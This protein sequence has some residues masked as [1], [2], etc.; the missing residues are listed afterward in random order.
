M[1]ID[2][3]NAAYG[4]VCRAI[5]DMSSAYHLMET[6]PSESRA[7]L[8]SA[9]RALLELK[10][11][12][13]KPDNQQENA[14]NDEPKQRMDEAERLRIEEAVRSAVYRLGN[15]YFRYNDGS[16]EA[17]RDL[18]GPEFGFDR[19]GTY[20][21]TIRCGRNGARP[22]R[23]SYYFTQIAYFLDTLE[24]DDVDAWPVKFDFDVP[25]D[26]FSAT[27]GLRFIGR[28]DPDEGRRP[29]NDTSKENQ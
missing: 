6:L 3:G 5:S 19:Y 2:T 24:T 27:F 11:M 20:T 22:H 28:T 7:H 13:E 26:V 8:Y 1:A 25:D 10:D 14:M 12:T 15:A 4:M 16:G 9:W 29:E 23:S 18:H 17:I 21:V